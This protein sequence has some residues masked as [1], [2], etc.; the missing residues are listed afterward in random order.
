MTEFFQSMV[1]RL[2]SLPGVPS[3]T[4]KH[5]QESEDML[6]YFKKQQLP[7]T[8]S[9]QPH[10]QP[11]HPQQ[12]RSHSTFH[13]GDSKYYLTD[14]ERRA[15]AD[16]TKKRTTILLIALIVVV[17][18]VAIFLIVQFDLVDKIADSFKKKNQSQETPDAM[19]NE[20]SSASWMSS[21]RTGHNSDDDDGPQP[22][23]GSRR[24][25]IEPP[26]RIPQL[27]NT[28]LKHV[29]KTQ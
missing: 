13:D 22:G 17:C 21:Y 20:R 15:P 7:R 27:S 29:R 10:P 3:S 28:I 11:P 14:E 6:P 8:L 2:R 16:R 12:S 9:Q 4:K 19:K 24:P 5:D 18:A 23:S 25:G 26:A 1:E